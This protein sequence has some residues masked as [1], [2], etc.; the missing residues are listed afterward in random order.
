MKKPSIADL[1]NA[2]G[3]SD[4]TPELVQRAMLALY[5]HIGANLDERNWATILQSAHPLQ[6]AEDA[7]R[8]MYQNSA[9]L[10][11]N[12]QHLE[13]SGHV[14]AQAEIT[15]RQLA[16]RLGF[17]HDPGWS[18]GTVYEH[19]G[20][21]SWAELV[22]LVPTTT[23]APLPTISVTSGAAGFTVALNVAGTVKLS[24]S[25]DLGAFAAGSTLLTE[26]VS[27]QEGYLTLAAGGRTSAATSAYVVLGTG[28]NN[29]IDTSA[30]GN[31]VDYI[32]GGAGDDTIQGG[33]G[34]DVLHGGDGNDRFVYLN[35][36]ELFAGN[37]LVDSIDGGTGTNALVLGD[38]VAH[39]GF[40]MTAAMSWAGMSRVSEL[41]AA[42]GLLDSRFSIVLNDDAYE[43]GLRTVSLSNHDALATPVN[44]INVSAETGAGNG[45]TL[46]GSKFSDVITGGAGNDAITGGMGADQLTGGLGADTFRVFASRVNSLD[47][48][49][50]FNSTQ[51]VLD[52]GIPV[53]QSGFGVAGSRE[54]VNLTNPEVSTGVTTVSLAADLARTVANTLSLRG[55]AYWQEA[56]DTIIVRLMGAS[57]AGN[58][59]LY[60]LQNQAND[61]T[62][63]AASE[64][65]VALTG[66]SM[67]PDDITDFVYYF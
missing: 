12:T 34:A 58:N 40:E 3:Y 1:L 27:I 67:V 65:V 33:G 5:G 35:A 52:L 32:F 24:V 25:G 46:E 6:A 64:V 26:Q 44:V 22:A 54:N 16:E 13:Q 62:F 61:S 23:P 19:L 28:G 55:P 36:G 31:R 7:L 60:V 18:A 47:V 66:V 45:Y 38:A 17:Q 41:R 30:A 21:L 14:A 49:G 37:A 50:D 2:S 59:V 4:Y 29:V 51:D 57:V 43:A 53:Y 48:I 63:D 42:G 8:A 20:P 9:Y 39:T 10:L 15:Y 56:G 11:R